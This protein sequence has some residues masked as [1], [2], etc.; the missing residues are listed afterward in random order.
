VWFTRRM[1][2]QA[3]HRGS[4][5][6]FLIGAVLVLGACGSSSTTD[7][8]VV[9][10]T[11]VEST[12]T[13]LAKSTMTT[14]KIYSSGGLE[15]HTE[16]QSSASSGEYDPNVPPTPIGNNTPEAVGDYI[17]SAANDQWLL[18]E[19]WQTLTFDSSSGVA[20]VVLTYIDE[21]GHPYLKLYVSQRDG[22]WHDSG[23]SSCTTAS[24][25]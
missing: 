21:H 25:Q 10:T 23:Y 13:T 9:A 8:L 7:D 4:V 3:R 11:V 14:E 1:A 12:T 22:I 19:D 5:V 20:D 6:P 17:M 2:K 18:R 15:C 16:L 24:D